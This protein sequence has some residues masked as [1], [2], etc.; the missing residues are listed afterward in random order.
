MKFKTTFLLLII[1]V[2][3]A[4][5]IIKVDSKKLST[6]EL[7]RIEKRVFKQFRPEQIT[8][9]QLTVTKTGE[10]E[11]IQEVELK[12]EVAGW[13]L[14]KPVNFPA[15]A[16][17]IRYMLDGIKKIDQSQILVGNDYKDFDKKSAGLENPP[18]I[19]MFETASTSVT[20]RIGGEDPIRWNH[21]VEIE[22]RD[23]LYIVPAH[24]KDSLKVE[25]DNT[26]E[27]FRRRD[28]FSAKKYGITA[29]T[30]ETPD[31]SIELKRDDLNMLWKVIDP[32]VDFAD[33][34]KIR[35]MI[36]NIV[37]MR[38][39]EF[40]ETPTNI[41]K[42]T[43]TLGVTQGASSQRLKV[44]K[45]VE[46]QFYARRAEY[47]QYFTLSEDDVNLFLGKPNDY[48]SRL[49]MIK[50]MF[51]KTVHLTQNVNGGIMDFDFKNEEW[52]IPGLKTPLQDDFKVEDYVDS[53]QD[54]TIS[55]FADS[56]VA[57]KALSNIW[58]TLIFKYE[59]LDE[60]KTVKLSRPKNGLVYAERSEGVFVTLAEKALKQFIKTDDLPFITDEIVDLPY[61]K[62]K[63]VTLE[64][65]GN[66]QKFY[67]SSNRWVYAVS[68]IVRETMYDITSDLDDL[69]PVYSEKCV[70]DSL[71]ISKSK[72]Q[73]FGFDNPF[74][75][76]SFITEN[77]KETT[78]IIG[79][80][81]TKTNR[82][83]MVKGETYV[84]EL[85]KETVDE[86]NLLFEF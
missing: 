11:K 56:A 48:R 50:N 19:A 83:A 76:Y 69:L 62:I 40:I 43:L 27:D 31:S 45:K 63:E 39:D 12:R 22:G 37:S 24:F 46:K 51:E 77:N 78:L 57:K 44:G 86:L 85:S 58:I 49:L 7:K 20:F 67:F 65:A 41:G 61:K 38:V 59:G 18:V 64:S 33:E 25:F 36:D 28:V 5:Y 55:N 71:K 21:Y 15:D 13:N 47:Q 53:W 10:V 84:F 72:L 1:A 4:Y 23:S 17:K 34:E 75:T 9:I 73:K 54:I 2:A 35:K 32:V 80:Q 29:L 81:T 79:G 8:R 82:F 66:L 16:P 68:N 42:N 6:E 14:V 52:Y 30:L 60:T 26:L 74:Q 70:A 3:A